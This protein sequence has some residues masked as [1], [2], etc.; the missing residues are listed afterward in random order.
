MLGFSYGGPYVHGDKHVHEIILLHWF[1]P[2]RAS[3]WTRSYSLMWYSDLRS[4]CNYTD[5]VIIL[6]LLP[7]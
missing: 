2:S 1:V 5:N 4:V 6:L 7:G 3:F